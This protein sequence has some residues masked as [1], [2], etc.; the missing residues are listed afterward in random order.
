MPRMTR[1][2]G[3]GAVANGQNWAR[4]GMRMSCSGDVRGPFT[5]QRETESGVNV[6][7]KRRCGIGAAVLA[8]TA[9]GWAS[10]SGVQ[11]I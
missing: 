1:S 10:G 11:I 4:Q 6:C 9:N 7:R 5:P 2:V 3:G 8:I